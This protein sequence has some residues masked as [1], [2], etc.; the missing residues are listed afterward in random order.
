MLYLS[1]TFTLPTNT[2]DISEELWKYR[3]GMITSDEY[4]KLTGHKPDE[5]DE[6]N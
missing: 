5:E 3:L 2:S 1:K 6:S 4:E